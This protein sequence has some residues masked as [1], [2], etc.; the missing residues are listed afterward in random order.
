MAV[1]RSRL[2][3]WPI[4]VDPA[5]EAVTAAQH[6]QQHDRVDEALVDVVVVDVEDLVWTVVASENDAGIVADAGRQHRQKSFKWLIDSGT[7]V[8]ETTFLLLVLLHYHRAEIFAAYHIS[9]VMRNQVW[10]E[11]PL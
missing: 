1:D 4:V 6:R 7:D 5:W 9:F 11:A 10:K 2:D 8:V 3:R